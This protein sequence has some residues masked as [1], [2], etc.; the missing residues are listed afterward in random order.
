MPRYVPVPGPACVW[1]GEPGWHSTS[2]QCLA[3]LT[4]AIAIEL[5]K[6]TPVPTKAA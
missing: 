1:C 2:D 3:A 5:E 4:R 6:R